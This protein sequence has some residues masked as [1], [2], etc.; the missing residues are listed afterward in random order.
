[1]GENNK[2]PELRF[3]EFYGAWKYVELENI[4]NRI[5]VGIAT[6]VSPYVSTSSDIPI[7]RNQNIRDGYF[8]SSD[9]IYITSDFDRK[10]KNKR[11]KHGDILIVRTGSNIGNACVVPI[12]FENSQ[13]FTTLIVRPRV[14][15]LDSQFLS[16]HINSNGIS[17]VKRLAAGAGKPNLNAGFLKKYRLALPKLPEQTKIANFL[18]PVDKRINLLTQQK[19]KLERYKKGVMQQIFS[20]QLRFKDDDGKAF[21][22]WE[23]KR[24]GEIGKLFSGGT[25]TSSKKEYYD[26]TIPFIKSGEISS[27]KT[28]QFLTDLGLKSSSAKMVSEGDLLIAIYGATSG[29]TA[30]AKIGGAINQ[31]VICIRGEF[32]NIFLLNWLKFNKQKIINTYLQGGQGN[33]SG[34]IIKSIQIN[35]PSFKEQQKIASF[36]SSIDKKIELVNQQIEQSKTWKKGLLQKMFV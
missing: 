30:I 24:L 22:V 23:E 25:P 26:G 35:L 14:E 28:V 8:D 15:I 18:T 7:I 16:L 9:I 29:E 31:A 27:K 3:P 13:T 10:N 6:E 1:M 4:T 5:T 36:L 32:D 34:E 11:V 21:P 2:I 12:Q 20:Q 19:E 17:E 33:L